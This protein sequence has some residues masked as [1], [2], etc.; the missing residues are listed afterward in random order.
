MKKT[1]V[2]FAT[3]FVL[4]PL[5]FKVLLVGFH[6]TS[7]TSRDSPLWGGYQNHIAYL[8]VKDVFMM[9]VSGGMAKSGRFALVPARA[10]RKRGGFHSSPDTIA[11]YEADPKEGSISSA[12]GTKLYVVGIVRKGTTF[13][14]I[15]L[16]KHDG[17]SLWTGGSTKTLTPWAEIVDGEYAGMEVDITDV[18]DFTR[19]PK[20]DD[21]FVY[22]PEKLFIKATD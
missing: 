10:D 21:I 3:V 16:E 6:S 2:I 13:R 7:E 8:L 17:W 22:E 1:V 20:I 15:R 12:T 4:L 19:L 14:T 5:V 9:K 18:S 11:A